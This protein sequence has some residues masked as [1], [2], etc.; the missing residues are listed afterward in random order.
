MT[1]KTRAIT[2]PA[3]RQA[4]F[5]SWAADSRLRLTKDREAVVGWRTEDA[6]L[7]T[8]VTFSVRAAD[9]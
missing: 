3:R 8:P 4:A 1:T 7:P 9:S 2:P 5:L 6:G